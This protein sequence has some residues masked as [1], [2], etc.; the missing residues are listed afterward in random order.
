M[1][2]GQHQEDL[3]FHYSIR[4]RLRLKN[5]VEEEEEDKQDR[6]RHFISQGLSGLMYNYC[7]LM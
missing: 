2:H 3:V 5:A 1:M 7:G 4:P 6:A